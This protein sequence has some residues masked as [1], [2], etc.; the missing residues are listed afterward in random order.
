MTSLLLKNAR[1]FDGTFEIDPCPKSDR[2]PAVI[3]PEAAV[4]DEWQISRDERL[5]NGAQLTA[6]KE[7]SIVN[8][9]NPFVA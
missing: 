6:R 1:I 5:S 4:V 9:D 8:D 7:R 2:Q 3:G